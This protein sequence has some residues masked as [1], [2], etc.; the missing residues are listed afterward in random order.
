MTLFLKPVQRRTS[1][2]MNSQHCRR[3]LLRGLS[4]ALLVA[5]VP[6]MSGAAPP[7]DDVPRPKALASDSALA[8][9]SAQAI[10]RV[11]AI[12]SAQAGNSAPAAKIRIGRIFFSPAERRHRYADKSAPAAGPDTSDTA[13]AERL[14]VNGA[15]S[16]STQG[17]AVWV[18]GVAIANSAKSTAWTD[19]SGRVWLRDDRHMP[20]RVQPGQAID[21]AS[22]AVDDLLPAGSVARR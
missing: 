15:I 13:G 16:S 9:N 20:H 21:P 2:K 6:A 1:V 5:L 18:N 12:N 3:L 4:L 11:Q 7:P 17:R 19:S 8:G 10:N 22:G 14:A